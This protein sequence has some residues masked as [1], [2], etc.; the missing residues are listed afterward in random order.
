MFYIRSIVMGA[1][2]CFSLASHAQNT[3]V[4]FNEKAQKSLVEHYN[5]YK[6]KE[7][8]SGGALSIYIP[9][10]DIK[11]Y[12]VGR[13]A[14]DDQTGR[15][16]T[17]NTLFQIGSITKSFT[18]AIILQLEKEKKLSIDDTLEKW[19]PQYSKWPQISIKSLLNMTSCLPNYSDT[20]LWNVDE[21]HQPLRRWKSEELVSYVYPKGELSPPLRQGYFYTN[22]GYILAS[23]I[24][25]KI[26]EHSFT[27]EL[28]ERT[29]NKAG[30]ENTFYPVPA[31]EIAI[32]SRLAHGYNYNQYDSPNFVGQNLQNNNLSWAAAAGGAV[33]NTEDI[34]K[35]VKA[36]FTEHVILDEAQQTK[37]KQIVS[38]Q[39]GKPVKET[40]STDPRAFGLGVAQGFD[41]HMGRYWYYEG[42]TLGYRAIYLYTPCNG[43]IIS[44]VFN[45]AVDAK[46]DHIGELMKQVFNLVQENY[47]KLKCK[48]V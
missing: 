24:V 32:Q 37:L 10:E 31:T 28:N 23:M 39:T 26:T 1:L 6:D 22:T 19:L 14:H 35:W 44:A 43:V 33:S 29:I 7:Y 2:F 9:G 25:E 12:Y 45:S 20:P 42:E 47:P 17:A 27:Q 34:I 11:N 36:L 3:D 48:P 15:D 30:L 41:K 18:A 5:R 46:N 38:E 21:F 16:I 8:F 13:T 4:S 40:T